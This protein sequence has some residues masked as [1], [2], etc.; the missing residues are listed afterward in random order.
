MAVLKDKNY[1]NYA[2]RKPKN[3][4]HIYAINNWAKKTTL[5]KL[6]YK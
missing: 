6:N 1:R 2:I 5:E 4:N 3:I